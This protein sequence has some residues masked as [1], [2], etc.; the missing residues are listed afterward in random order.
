MELLLLLLK[1][2]GVL[3]VLVLMRVLMRVRR[4]ELRAAVVSRIHSDFTVPDNSLTH[5]LS[6]LLLL[7][8]CPIKIRLIVTNIAK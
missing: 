3:G 7:H 4:E 5:S 6:Q 8:F 2:L 1:V